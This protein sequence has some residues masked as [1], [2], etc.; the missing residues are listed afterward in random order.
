M[1]NKFPERLK[2]LRIEKGLIQKDLAK[3]TGLSQSAIAQWE[4]KKRVPNADAI[5]VLARY[6]G[7]TADYLLGLENFTD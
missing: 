5:I 6:F 3:A 2:E 4:G 7:V 1:T